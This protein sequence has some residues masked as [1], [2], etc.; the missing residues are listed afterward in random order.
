MIVRFNVVLL[1]S[2]ALNERSYTSTSPYMT[3]IFAGTICHALF[4]ERK[5]YV[6]EYHR[7]KSIWATE[8]A[9]SKYSS[10]DLSLEIPLE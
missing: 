4:A 10:P 1:H 8:K 7:I 3:I 5:Y 2:L 6:L 9:L